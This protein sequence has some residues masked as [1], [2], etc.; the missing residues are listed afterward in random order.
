MHCWFFR[1]HLFVF[2]PLVA[3]GGVCMRVCWYV[4]L[5]FLFFAAL[6]CINS[7]TASC[8]KGRYVDDRSGQ[9]YV[10]AHYYATSQ[11]KP[12]L[13]G[14]C[15]FSPVLHRS[16]FSGFLFFPSEWPA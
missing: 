9:L 10:P 7:S 12:P 1:L 8:Q 6:R 15:D 2:V 11:S 13:V 16:A 5:F 3:T 14:T 4:Y